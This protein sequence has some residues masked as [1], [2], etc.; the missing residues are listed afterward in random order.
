VENG[1]LARRVAALADLEEEVRVVDRGRA[2]Q[3]V[4]DLVDDERGVAPRQPVQGPASR[5]CNA[6][7]ASIKRQ[8]RPLSSSWVQYF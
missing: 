1:P 8:V 7:N 3:H 5:R 6:A 2:L 4:Q